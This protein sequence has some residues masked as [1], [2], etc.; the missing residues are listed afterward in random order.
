MWI[1]RG[2]VHDAA[3]E[4]K[5]FRPCLIPLGEIERLE[6]PRVAAFATARPLKNALVFL[7]KTFGRAF[8]RP[9]IGALSSYAKIRPEIIFTR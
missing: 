2:A 1:P 9:R 3:G 4:P 7:L 5:P 8:Q 6:K